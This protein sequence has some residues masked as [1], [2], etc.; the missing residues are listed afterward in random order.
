MGEKKDWRRLG[1]SKKLGVKNV[2]PFSSLTVSDGSLEKICYWGQNNDDNIVLLQYIV[3]H[4]HTPAVTID[5]G[6]VFFFLDWWS[7]FPISSKT[8]PEIAIYLRPCSDVKKKTE[9]WQHTSYDIKKIGFIHSTA[10]DAAAAARQTRLHYAATFWVA[11]ARPAWPGLHS[12]CC[13]SDD[14]H[15]K[16]VASI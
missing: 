7:N 16:K 2:T 1:G 9:S 8:A 14:E 13:M 10:A 11:P 3:G 12:F 6:Q 4:R 15:L 5:H